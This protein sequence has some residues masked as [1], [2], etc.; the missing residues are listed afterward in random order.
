[1]RSL[2]FLKSASPGATYVTVVA[3]AMLVVKVVFLN[4]WPAASAFLYE[5]GVLFEAVLASVV[6]SYIFY[7]F[8]VHLKEMK[9]KETVGPYIDRKSSLVVGDCMSQIEAIAT[10]S[11]TKIAFEDISVDTIRAAFAKIAPYS[12]APLLLGDKNANWF[13]YFYYFR[14]RSLNHIEK[15]MKQLVY[16][17]VTRVKLLAEVEDCS[18]FAMLDYLQ[19]NK[20]RNEN[21]TAWATSF[22]AY[23]ALCRE[24]NWH[25]KTK[26]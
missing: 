8:V 5:F 16:V 3:M 6:A 26:H 13:Q 4:R 14:S 21:L 9:D 25:L 12:D 17:D 1:M 15:V 10:A 23:C 7:L 11:G 19:N 20:V 22:F 2:S 18:H 24:L